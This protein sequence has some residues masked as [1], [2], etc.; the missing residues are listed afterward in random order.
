MLLFAWFSVPRPE[1]ADEAILVDA[2]VDLDASNFVTIPTDPR[3]ASIS[4]LRMHPE[5]GRTWVKVA[6]FPQRSRDFSGIRKTPE[7]YGSK[8]TAFFE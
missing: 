8:K 3:V 4:A 2:V 5:T 7:E 6:S 1:F